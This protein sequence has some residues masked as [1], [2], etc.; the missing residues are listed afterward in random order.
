M[1][2]IYIILF[3]HLWLLVFPVSATILKLSKTLFMN[4]SGL[5]IEN[6][7]SDYFYKWW[8]KG[9]SIQ[10][11]SCSNE[12]RLLQRSLTTRQLFP[13]QVERDPKYG[14]SDVIW[15]ST[16]IVPGARNYRDRRGIDKRVRAARRHAINGSL[17]LV[18]RFAIRRWKLRA[19][20]AETVP[21][22]SLAHR[23]VC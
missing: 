13:C 1:L 4:N 19:L 2:N 20:H 22:N 8:K 23:P 16:G 9:R 18:K 7:H 10:R 5:E 11:K 3:F 15:K 21:G 14:R 17:F 6:E 12:Q